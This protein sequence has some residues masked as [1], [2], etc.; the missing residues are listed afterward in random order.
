MSFW[1]SAVVEMMFALLRPNP[2]VFR[3]LW[4]LLARMEPSSAEKKKKKKKKKKNQPVH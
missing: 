1:D 3:L 4:H 2:V